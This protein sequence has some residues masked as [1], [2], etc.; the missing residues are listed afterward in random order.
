MV[1][2]QEPDP[3]RRPGWWIASDGQ[4]YPPEVH[5]SRRPGWWIA[6]DEQWYPP[7]LHPNRKTETSR[8]ALVW[9]FV[10]FACIAFVGLVGSTGE[11]SGCESVSEAEHAQCIRDESAGLAPIAV[12]GFISA[13]VGV[14]AAVLE[15]EREA[16]GYTAGLRMSP[17]MVG[18][19]VCGCLALVADG[20][21]ALSL[22]S[23]S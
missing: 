4:W 6:S 18:A 16:R 12:A 20:F 1:V 23:A 21:A 7:A 15:S 9:V 13:C 22:L 14:V 10:G 5:P 17:S 2:E 11:G 3:S 8:R 19:M